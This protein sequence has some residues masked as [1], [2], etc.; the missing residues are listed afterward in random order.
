MCVDGGW[1]SAWHVGLQ[2]TTWNIVLGG[3]VLVLLTGPI[4]VPLQQLHRLQALE[5]P[6]QNPNGLQALTYLV[7]GRSGPREMPLTRQLNCDQTIQ[8][9][10]QIP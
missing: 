8:I 5:V 1:D 7:P 9:I 4:G 3:L 6:L 10:L 2:T